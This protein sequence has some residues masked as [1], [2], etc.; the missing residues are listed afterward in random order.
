MGVA[1]LLTE[2]SSLQLAV[3]SVAPGAPLG[4]GLL[5]HNGVATYALVSGSEGT[6]WLRSL[7]ARALRI[8]S[9]LSSIR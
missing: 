8:D 4:G 3:S 6:P 7:A 1:P 9:P 2:A 5:A